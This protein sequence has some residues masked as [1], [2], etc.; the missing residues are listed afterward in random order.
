[1]SIHHQLAAVLQEALL[2]AQSAGALPTFT[3]PAI[4]IERPR[5]A[6]FGDYAS[7][8][9]LKLARD[10]RMAP[11]KIAQAMVDHLTRHD[12][13]QEMTRCPAWIYQYSA[14]A[15]AACSRLRMMCWRRGGIRPYPLLV[16][17]KKPKSNASAPIPPGRS[18]S[19]VPGAASWAIP[20]PAPCVLLATKS[21]SNITTTTPGGRSPCWA[22]PPKSVTLQLLGQDVNLAE[23]ITRATTSP[24]LPGTAAAHGDSLQD[25]PPN[26]FAIYAKDHIA[27]AKKKLCAVSTSSLTFTTTSKAC[28]KPGAFGKRWKLARKGVRLQTRGCPM[29]Q[30]HRV[31]RRQRPCPCQITRRTHLPYARHCL[32]LGQSAARLRSRRGLFWPRSSRYC[33][34]KC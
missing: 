14:Y 13:I 8:T 28:M 5:A 29:V 4:V 24:I 34:R 2:A 21:S 32:P 18:I 11:I 16:T 26:Y 10:A 23:S 33:A 20:W 27:K 19:A 6:S 7:P 1:M 30:N 12:Y 15:S 9:P 31:W 17:A 25:E 3:P 22:N